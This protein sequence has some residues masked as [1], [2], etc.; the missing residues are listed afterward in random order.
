MPVSLGPL[1]RNRKRKEELR[2]RQIHRDA[3]TD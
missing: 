3:G 2:A 1:T